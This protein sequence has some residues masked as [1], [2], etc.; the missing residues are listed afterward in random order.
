MTL[1]DLLL[2][3]VDV[4]KTSA[5][6][7]FFTCDADNNVICYKTADKLRKLVDLDTDL[8]RERLLAII[9]GQN[10]FDF[11]A[12][13]DGNFY[14]ETEKLQFLKDI[15]V[16]GDLYGFGDPCQ[17]N[18]LVCIRGTCNNYDC[19]NCPGSKNGYSIREF[20]V[21][22]KE[23]KLLGTSVWTIKW[24]TKLD[25]LYDILEWLQMCHDSLDVMVVNFD[26]TPFDD[27]DLS[28]DWICFAVLITGNK[29]RFITSAAECKSLFIEYSEK[30]ECIDY[31]IEE[32]INLLSTD[33]KFHFPRPA[34][35]IR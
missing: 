32:S 35:A 25:L 10:Y 2:E 4:S 20:P 23:R 18:Q 19:S 6:Y 29:I 13:K 16:E 14:I 28:Y 9:L 34:A 15:Q 31:L 24:A 26:F 17:R 21:C 5:P 3:E 12:A 30:Y 7:D 22:N 8:D 27:N 1:F 33:G 11:C